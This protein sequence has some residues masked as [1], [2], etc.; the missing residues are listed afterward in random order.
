MPLVE[1]RSYALPI[2]AAE[3]DYVRD[4]VVPE[5]T[6]DPHSPRSI[7]RAVRRHLGRRDKVQSLQDG[8]SF[9]EQLA[10]THGR[11]LSSWRPE[12]AGL[13]IVDGRTSAG[14]ENPDSAELVT[15]EE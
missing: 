3:L 4:V 6:F 8:K 2:V 9:L 5:E 11:T 13:P 1:A 10:V 12:L 7:A 14:D 15:A